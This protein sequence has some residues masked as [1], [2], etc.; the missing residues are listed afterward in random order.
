[1]LPLPS[2]TT[3]TF[4]E[5]TMEQT[6][7]TIFIALTSR[8]IP[9]VSLLQ[10][11]I[12]SRPLQEIDI[13]QSSTTDVFTS[14]VDMMDTIESMIFIASVFRAVL[15]IWWNHST[16]KLDQAHVI[17]TLPSSMKI[18]CTSLAATMV[19]IETTFTN[20]TSQQTRGR[21]SEET[22]CGLNQDT[23]P[24]QPS[25]ITECTY[26]EDMMEQDSLMTS[27]TPTFRLRLGHW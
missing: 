25:L 22:G 5:G 27:I 12:H 8:L 21:K 23:E 20:T 26:S 10:M 13:L 15:G 4:S 6:G 24:L 9:G 3:S 1:M 16:Q 18:T 11:E 7:V 17:H 19:T 2:K 14:L